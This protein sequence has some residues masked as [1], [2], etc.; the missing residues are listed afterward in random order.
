MD[1]NAQVSSAVMDRTAEKKA[2]RSKAGYVKDGITDPGPTPEGPTREMLLVATDVAIGQCAQNIS[3]LVANMARGELR[4]HD[5]TTKLQEQMGA[6]SVCLLIHCDKLGG[7]GQAILNKYSLHPL[8][9]PQR[10]SAVSAQPVPPE[11]GEGVGCEPGSGVVVPFPGP[12]I[13]TP[14][15]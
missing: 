10:P 11:A 7:D 3:T 5:F 13:V 8:F 15:S 9:P 1:S 4:P 2:R 12:R 6:M 14:N